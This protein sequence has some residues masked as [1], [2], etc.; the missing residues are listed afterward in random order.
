MRIAS[1]V[2]ARPQFVKVAPVARALAN[3]SGGDAVEHLIVHTGQHYDEGMS[4]VFFRELQ[5]P[6]PDVNL[7]IGSGSHGAQT[8]RML[9]AI[10]NFL[11]D[12][13]PDAVI[14]YGDTNSTLAGA[15]AATK[16]GIRTAH[17]EAGLRSFNRTMPEELNRIAT[18]HV[19]DLLLAPTATAAANLAREGLRE[20]TQLVGDVM[21]D[22]LRHNA[23]LARAR[24]R[25]VER[26]ELTGQRYAVATVHRAANTE[27]APLAQL[28]GALARIA[29]EMPVVL[30]LHPRTRA[31]LRE[32]DPS[33]Q[34]ARDLRVVGPVPY[35]D[36]LRLVDAA[37]VV[38]T[39]SGGLQKEA[40]MLGRPCI[41]LRD[42]TEW[43]ETLDAGANI[44][45]GTEAGRVLAA[46]EQWRSQG[47]AEGRDLSSAADDAYGE[48]RAAV[49]IAQAACR[50]A[51][52]R[53]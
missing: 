33:G 15:L 17:V 32:V 30:P 4:D 43:T 49:K 7:E 50:L 52:V 41:T 9:E 12:R 29:R 18:D 42:E 23:A 46:F 14:V 35:L 40:F 24:S 16:L 25:V 8:G 6:V 1:I 45:A 39:D 47:W 5:I 34:L 21:L 51:T 48:A 13:A 11:S 2:G 37:S 22:A 36:M 10:E 28:L 31:V 44:L 3:S 27:P 26:L 53:N 20:R 38:L 19:S